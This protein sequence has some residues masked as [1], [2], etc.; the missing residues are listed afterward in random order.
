MRFTDKYVLVSLALI[1]FFQSGVFAQPAP[2]NFSPAE[3]VKRLQTRPTKENLTAA[4][5]I[6]FALIGENKFEQSEYVFSEILKKFPADGWSLYGNAIGLFNLKQYEEAESEAAKAENVF[7]KQKNNVALADVL[8]LSAVITAV[9]GI[10]AEAIEKLKKAVALVPTHFDANFSLGRA[11]FGSGDLAA[12][13][14]AFRAALKQQPRNVKANFFLA[15][16]LERDGD[17][18]NALNIYRELVK[19]SP[20]FAEGYLGLGVLLIK[21]DG[22]NSSEG[23]ENLRKAV[24]I[25]SNLYEAQVTLGKA[26]LRQNKTEEALIYLQKAVELLPDN[27]EPHYQLLQVFRKLGKKSEAETEQA[28]I[29]K[30]HENHRGSSA[31]PVQ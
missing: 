21:T 23:L 27:P 12:S 25:N 6:G 9:T 8:V 15:S 20:A 4:R 10:N 28:I 1:I 30:I 5:K 11:Y 26:L 31:P 16:A 19:I 18:T 3:T 14:A 13:I 29:K 24:E 22:E 7:G 17:T 2:E